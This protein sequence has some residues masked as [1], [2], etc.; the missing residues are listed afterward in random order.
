MNANTEIIRAALNVAVATFGL[1]HLTRPAGSKVTGL[2]TMDGEAVRE[3]LISHDWEEVTDEANAKGVAAG[4]CRYFRAVINEEYTGLE[5]I[6]LLRD[7]APEDLEAVRVAIGHHG[8]PEFQI[9]GMA[10]RPTRVMHLFIGDFTNYPDGEYNPETAGV[11]SWYPGR[12]TM[13]V[14][15]SG[16]VVKFV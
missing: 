5:G 1:K 16:A 8:E 13:P 12:L 3:F 15:L 2:D 7:L 11:A 14:P 4:K 10:S 6:C 9:A